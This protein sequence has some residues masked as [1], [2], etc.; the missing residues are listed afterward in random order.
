[1]PLSLFLDWYRVEPG[2][3][4]ES[5][6]RFHGWD[7]F[8]TTDA[9]MVLCAVAALLLAVTAGRYAGRMLIGVGMLATTFVVV[10]LFSKPAILG[11]VNTPGV[12]LGVGAWL[13]LAGALL[14]LGAGAIGLIR[15]P[16]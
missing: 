11:L 4:R 15:R 12:S 7:V 16:G 10:A 13:G 5:S 14:V 9:V 8:E 2:I 6:E 3:F 1:M